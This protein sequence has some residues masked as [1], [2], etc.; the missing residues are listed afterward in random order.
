MSL[1]PAVLPIFILH[2]AVSLRLCA[3]RAMARSAWML[4]MSMSITVLDVPASVD[5]AT[6]Q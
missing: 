3:A 2:D 4:P 1:A 6:R 5:L